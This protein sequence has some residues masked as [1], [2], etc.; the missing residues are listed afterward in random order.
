MIEFIDN[1]RSNIDIFYGIVAEIRQFFIKHDAN[2]CLVAQPL[3]DIH[4]TDA[5][6]WA[7]WVPSMKINLPLT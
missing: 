4:D 2:S 5:I 6:W 7:K 1:T 3:H